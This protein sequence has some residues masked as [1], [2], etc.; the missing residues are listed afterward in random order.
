M[1]L[2]PKLVAAT[3]LGAASLAVAQVDI[4]DPSIPGGSMNTAVRIVAT[5][6]LMI[7]RF[8][9]RWIR[10]HY[11]GWDADPYQIQELGPDRYA[12]VYITAPGKTARRVYFK[13]N[14]SIR[15]DD[16][17]GFPSL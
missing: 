3:L 4:P 6:D 9:N 2:L 14:K 12:V 11:P 5:N 1:K 8:I 15:D 13:V 10:T 16:D 17:T 7:D